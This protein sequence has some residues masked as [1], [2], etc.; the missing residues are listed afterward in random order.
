MAVSELAIFTFA[1][2]CL[3]VCGSCG[4]SIPAWTVDLGRSRT[5]FQGLAVQKQCHYILVLVVLMVSS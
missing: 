3:C 2:V 1:S 4:G 5:L